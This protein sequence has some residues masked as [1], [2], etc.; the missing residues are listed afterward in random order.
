MNRG[1]RII[2]I[3]TVVL[4]PLACAVAG[5]EPDGGAGASA[6]A[7]AGPTGGGDAGGLLDADAATSLDADSP[8]DAG[9]PP[10]DAGAPAACDALPGV[11]YTDY[12]V[13]ADIPRDGSADASTALNT[14]LAT[15]PDGA[16]RQ[17]RS[18]VV[19]PTAAPNTY[20]LDVGW[21]FTD[22]SNLTFQGNGATLKVGPS[23]SG[24]DQ[25][26]SAFVLGHEFGGYW[27]GLS[28]NITIAGFHL[29]GNS[30]HPGVF[31]GGE[32]QANVELESGDGVEICE[33][34]AE[35]AWGDFV[36]IGGSS[37]VRIHHNHV[38]DAG[39]NAVS[40]IS[41]S[42]IEIDSN[43]FDEV[44]YVSFDVEPNL[45]TESC[46][47]IRFHDNTLGSWGLN[48]FSLDGSHTGAPIDH[49]HVDHNV[50]TGSSLEAIVNNG[51]T[52]RNTDIEFSWNT[53]TASAVAGPVL[54]FSHVDGLVIIH[55]DQPLSSGTL[56]SITDCTQ[57][58]L[59]PNP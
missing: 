37:H 15:I 12:P 54:Y 38:I 45:P 2:T 22:R 51:G 11:T 28:S 16:D 41:G 56:L 27:H 42:D 35:G 3:L 29:V 5:D 43:A 7:D 4:A 30:A 34:V 23:A 19:F 10:P 24:G 13:P 59:A 50:V 21:Q 31:G 8:P 39:R 49:V 6:P 9:S 58:T 36:K 14:W 52:T 17:H 48:F 47:S 1:S 20:R 33:N 46:Q 44:G 55:N 18:R 25:L 26:A 57:T 40:V 32:H 53:S